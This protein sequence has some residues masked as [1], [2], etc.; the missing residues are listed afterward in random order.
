MWVRTGWSGRFRPLASEVELESGWRKQAR[1][2]EHEKKLWKTRISLYGE[3]KLSYFIKVQKTQKRL[4]PSAHRHMP[5]F[6]SNEILEQNLTFLKDLVSLITAI[7]NISGA[8]AWFQRYE[9]LKFNQIALF[10]AHG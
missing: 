9:L 5:K 3:L 10:Y 2:E 1:N 4:T 6:G 7:Y 8:R